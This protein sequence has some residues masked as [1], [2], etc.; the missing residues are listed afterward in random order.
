[1]GINILAV[2]YLEESDR[3][4]SSENDIFTEGEKE[5]L[6]RYCDGTGMD[7]P[8]GYGDC[9]A[10]VVFHYRT[11]NNTISILGAENANWRGIFP[12]YPFNH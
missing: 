11:P 9:Q 3:V 12:R 6:R 7:N 2:H 5:T 1:M 8:S 10:K 4:F